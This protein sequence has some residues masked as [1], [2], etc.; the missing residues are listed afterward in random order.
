MTKKI[1]TRRRKTDKTTSKRHQ[2]TTE[3]DKSTSKGQKNIAIKRLKTTL[4]R[5]HLQ[6]YKTS[7]K[8]E[9]LA[10]IKQGWVFCP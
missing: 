8:T 10:P 7:T 6:S 4:N 2:T 9:D 5:K 3:R 1:H